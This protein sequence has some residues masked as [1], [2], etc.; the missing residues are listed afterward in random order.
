LGFGATFNW[1]AFNPLT[2]KY[3]VAI[4]AGES[5]L[6][7]AGLNFDYQLTNRINLSLGFSLT[8]FS[9]GA[10]KKPNFG[11]NTIAPKVSLK[12]NFRDIPEFI[13]Q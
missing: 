1:Q 13:K 11:I 8:H 7:D 5:F 4:G 9:N 6:I 12:Y 10:L 3:N 2:N